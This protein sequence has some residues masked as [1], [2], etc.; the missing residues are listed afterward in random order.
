MATCPLVLRNVAIQKASVPDRRVARRQKLPHDALRSLIR[1]KDYDS[2]AVNEGRRRTKRDFLWFS[3]PIFLYLEP[4]HR[5]GEFRL[6][7]L[8]TLATG[9]GLA[10]N[11]PNTCEP[12]SERADSVTQR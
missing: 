3:L 6:G 10:E 4:H 8:L 9:L 7:V 5:T 12:L 11:Q 1:G 2:V